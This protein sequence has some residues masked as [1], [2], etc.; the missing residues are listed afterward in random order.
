MDE[1]H[2]LVTALVIEEPIEGNPTNMIDVV[3][4]EPAIT[5][6]A[7]PAEE[8]SKTRRR[9]S[10]TTVPRWTSEE[11]EQLTALVTSLGEKAW[12]EVS[13]QLGSGRTPSGVEQHWQIM[14]G[15]RKRD[16]KVIEG[17]AAAEGSE[18]KAAKS[19]SKALKAAVRE[20]KAEA[21]ALERSIKEVRACALCCVIPLAQ[22]LSW[23][24][25][26]EQGR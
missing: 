3:L 26:G 11:E 17:A 5:V 7:S 23:R 2:P 15:K 13:T 20:A 9:R 12:V 1:P 19:E 16:G 22:S 14:T 6:S 18:A 4:A 8:L 25:A 24:L 10:R 21:R